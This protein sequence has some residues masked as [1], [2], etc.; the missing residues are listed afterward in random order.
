M[1]PSPAPNERALLFTLAGIQF[2]HIVD[3]MVMMPLGPQFTRLFGISDAQ[4][5]LL[6]SAYTLAAG[7]SGLAASAF[8]DRF[9]RKSLLLSLYAAFALATLACGLAPTYALLMV[10]RIAAGLFGGVMGALVQTMVGDAIP[11]ER[12]GRAMGVVMASFSLATVAGVP[13]SLALAEALSWHAS[14]VAIALA[15]FVIGAVGL[16][17]LPRL[18]GH[19]QAARG[20]SARQALAAVL[21]EPNHWR[22]FGFSALVMGS[23]FTVIPFLTIYLTSNVGVAPAQVPLI[24]LAGGVATLFTARLIGAL[25][26]RWGKVRAFRIVAALA[27]L[28]MLAVTHLG[29]TPLAVVLVVSTAFFVFVSGRM[30]PGM[31]LVTSASVPSLRGAFMSLNGSLQSAAMGLAAMLGGALIGRDTAGTVQGY[32]RCGW[33][34][35]L[36]TLVSL[37]WVARLRVTPTAAV[38]PLR[39]AAAG[40]PSPESSSPTPASATRGGCSS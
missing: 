22:A 24:Y 25:A 37:W 18:T 17:T 2:T 23:S 35:A 39:S 34:A 32:E 16:R 21:R 10:A 7:V 5:G 33:I 27:L 29:P 11:F 40:S 12:R 36:L 38:T 28:P 8:I 14:F 6:V 9:E 13:A 1:T 19:L 30:V 4:F 15:S 31:A 20:A 26:D 3:F